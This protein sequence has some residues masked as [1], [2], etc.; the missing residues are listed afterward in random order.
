MREE[1]GS[2]LGVTAA[3]LALCGVAYRLMF[4][5]SA[6]G[7]F[8]NG[9]ADV[10]F[11]SAAAAYLLA[12]VRRDARGLRVNLAA[13]SL[14]LFFL[15]YLLTCRTSAYPRGGAA[16]LADLAAMV[17]LFAVVS[18][19]LFGQDDA[20][21]GA[22]FLAAAAV[23]PVAVGFFQHYYE[24][25]RQL[26]ELRHLQL[27][28]WVGNVYIDARNVEDFR[29]RVE[30]AEVFSTFYTSNVF[31]GFL[32]LALPVTLGLG[33]GILGGTAGRKSKVA[34]AAAGGVL[35][36]GEAFL[37]VM[38]KSKAGTAA[39]G[40]ALGIFVVTAAYHLL[41][42]KAFFAIVV[43]GALLG[44]AGLWLALPRAKVF[45]GEV[46]TS[47]YVRE[48]YWSATWRLIEEDPFT[49]VGPGNFSET[50][51]AYKDIG[52]R[53]VRNPHNAYLLVWA[54][55]GV[56]SLLFFASFLAL[57]FAGPKSRGDAAG[58]RTGF[59]GAAAIVAAL[60]LYV[61]VQGDISGVDAALTAA[62][63]AAAA[64]AAAF[65]AL[66][67]PLGETADAAL[68][69]AGLAAG[70]AGFCI[71]SAVDVTF[72]DAGATT[73]AIFAAAVLSPRGKAAVLR[74]GRRGTILVAALACVVLVAF[75][76]RFYV[77]YS[78]AETI[79][80]EARELAEKGDAASAANRART[81]LT[82]DPADSAIPTF[83]GRFYE[84]V[85]KNE[86]ARAQASLV[87]EDYYNKAANLDPMN[88]AA[89]EGLVRIFNAS[90]PE[91]YAKA[92]AV[93]AQLLQLYP[94]NSR[95]HIGAARVLE[96]TGFP[97]EALGHYRRG[98]FIDDYEEQH[99]VQLD[100]EELAEA[101]AA[102]KRLA[103]EVE[104][105]GQ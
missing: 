26:E 96:K 98:V 46:K 101:R 77:P 55:G 28:G 97:A 56:F 87:A 35:A 74:G 2:P 53:E 89:R 14:M 15:A 76:A 7:F 17:C 78:Q 41:P 79:M 60:A 29:T 24:F 20:G 5:S 88:R 100:K 102:I 65:A 42:R 92:I 33:A 67:W 84:A 30:S 39:A 104:G 94:T 23:I 64:A 43:A 80:E 21:R 12:M 49:G 32:A 69:R 6:A 22:T 57:V 83:L 38:T 86:A 13:G 45:L 70:V 52:E 1:K 75:V 18:G 27:P 66:L 51:V 10:I 48:G 47:F 58:P 73:A 93:Y 61:F 91:G 81:A 4:S 62:I 34:A 36:A 71:H 95:Y 9:L 19:A 59:R 44:G 72:S 50:Y 105:G 54:E 16:E 25:P 40:I 99:G 68:V 3:V 103:A 90:G 82:L 11:F 63:A 8:N 37:L 31:A 85:S